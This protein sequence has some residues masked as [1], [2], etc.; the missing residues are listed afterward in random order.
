M[1]YKRFDPAVGL[2]IEVKG[3][4]RVLAVD[5]VIVCAGQLPLKCAVFFSP[6]VLFLKSSH[7][8]MS[9]SGF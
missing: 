4:E 6:F 5:N 1:A 2:V 7:L 8:W 9:L 3:K